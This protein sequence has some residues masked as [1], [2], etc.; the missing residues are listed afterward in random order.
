MRND[1]RYVDDDA[2]TGIF[3][4]PSAITPAPIGDDHRLWDANDVARYLKVSRS[5]VYH[6]AEAGLLPLR[7]VGGLLRFDPAAIRA[8]ATGGATNHADGGGG[9]SRT[10]GPDGRRTRR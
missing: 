8:F 2:P 6:R 10:S 3:T 9:G 4:R 1:N 5:W 7:R